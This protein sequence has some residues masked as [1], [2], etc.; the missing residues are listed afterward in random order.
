MS[1]APKFNPVLVGDSLANLRSAADFVDDG[2]PVPAYDHDR[3]VSASP[4][5]SVMPD[6]KK[7][8]GVLP[9]TEE[10]LALNATAE[11]R[12]KVAAILGVKN[13]EATGGDEIIDLPPEHRAALDDI[14]RRV[15]G[16]D[17]VEGVFRQYDEANALFDCDAEL[18]DRPFASFAERNQAAL[19][20][21]AQVDA[22]LAD[23][24]RAA[25]ELQDFYSRDANDPVMK[26]YRNGDRNTKEMMT[27]LMQAA[28]GEPVVGLPKDRGD[29]HIY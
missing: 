28:H 4:P 15:G 11:G 24:A 3:S 29:G 22:I 26:A 21:I 2:I 5:E 10:L 1:D 12:A 23:P 7:P 18:D 19:R 6:S 16:A 14:A 25:E 27:K 20:L 9:S 13:R 17:K 8:T